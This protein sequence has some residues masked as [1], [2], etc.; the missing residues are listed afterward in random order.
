MTK[1]QQIR[2][3][4]NEPFRDVVAGFADMGYSRKMTARVLE[5]NPSWFDQLCERFDL[6]KHFRSRKEYISICKPPG[7]PKGKSV[8]RP[9][10]AY[11]DRQLLA[12][13]RRHDEKVSAVDFTKIQKKPCA[14][15]YLHR[16]GSWSKA[17]MLAHK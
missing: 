4:F 11:S 14:N 16:F 15:T 3:E 10:Q 12:I 13:L 2:K 6:K 1:V 17:K 8:K 9:R 7:R 5:V